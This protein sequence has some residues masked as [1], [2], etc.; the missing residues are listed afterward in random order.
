MW[1]GLREEIEIELLHIRNAF[2]PFKPLLEEITRR[3]PEA[4]EIAAL[5]GLLHSFYTGV[6]N[7]F[8]RIAVHV[9]RQVPRGEDWHQS[10]LNAMTR[11]TSRRPAVMSQELKAVLYEYLKFRHVFRQGYM[12]QLKWDRMAPLV[13][14][15]EPTFRRF[16]MELRAFLKAAKG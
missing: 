2:K 11:S 14:K 4:V 6:E 12:H 15:A 16:R 8:K 5:G 9:D 3:P 10:L 13:V 1:P 7:V